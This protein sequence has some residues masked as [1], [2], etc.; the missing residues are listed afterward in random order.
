MS[1]ATILGMVLPLVSKGVGWLFDRFF[2]HGISTI[3]G[4]VAGAAIIALLEGMGC[5]L[6]MSQESVLGLIGA[7]PGWLATDGNKTG[8]SLV[9]AIKDAKRPDT[10]EGTPTHS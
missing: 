5:N 8:K 4:T 2:A 9:E 7:L 6:S 1:I 3:Q 10:A